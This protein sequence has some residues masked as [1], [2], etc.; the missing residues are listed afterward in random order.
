MQL[1]VIPL[2]NTILSSFVNEHA[3]LACPKVPISVDTLT[4]SF[5]SGGLAQFPANY[6][7]GIDFKVPTGNVLKFD[8]RTKV[9]Q[10]GD[11]V[12][13]RDSIGTLN[14]F[15]SPSSV[16]YAA[17]EKAT[18]WVKT[19]SN[20]SSFRFTWEYIDV[21]GFTEVGN[22]SRTIIP[23][24]LTANHY[25]QFKAEFGATTVSTA[26]L[27]GGVDSS[28][29]NI[30]VYD[31][32]NLNSKFVGNLEQLLK[33]KTPKSTGRYLTL[34]NFYRLPSDS[35]LL[36]TEYSQYRNYDFVI[37][38]K[39]KPYRIKKSATIDKYEISTET[40]FYCI[41]SNETYLT[42][43]EFGHQDALVYIKPFSNKDS[44]DKR[45]VYGNSES[46]SYYSPRFDSNHLLPQLISFNPFTIEVSQGEIEFE[47]KSGPM[48][49]YTQVVPLCSA[50]ETVKFAFNVENVKTMKPGEALLVEI[51]QPHSFSVPTFFK[52]TSRSHRKEAIGTYMAVTFTGTTEESTFTMN[53]IIDDI[54]N[55][56][57][58]PM[59][60]AAMKKTTTYDPMNW[61]MNSS[62][63]AG[64][65]VLVL[66]VALM[67]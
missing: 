42:D 29:K 34:V 17:A 14:E 60:R 45:I 28:L 19:E 36:V 41:D 64:F 16:F 25:Y 11:K 57:H 26:S 10:P 12:V 23:L 50:T 61:A 65:S 22:P 8:V 46:S 44:Y 24:N 6:D 9:D 49:D 31:G 2:I 1:S 52:F 66:I 32:N 53:Y 58:D 38:S 62:V 3:D 55:T 4:G 13:I 15:T 7:C 27:S 33:K 40:V 18:I 30:F 51:G 54:A 59:E 43:L 39:N 48:E 63:S 5:P 37:L 21:S 56:T 67:F 20:S 35:Y 47:L